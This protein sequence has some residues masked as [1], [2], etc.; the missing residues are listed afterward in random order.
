MDQKFLANFIVFDFKYLQQSFVGICAF[1]RLMRLREDELNPRNDLTEN[2]SRF[3]VY[4]KHVAEEEY[5]L[6][7]HFN[8]VYFGGLR[9]RALRFVLAYF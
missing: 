9:E 1:L 4:L 3:G 2:V 8:V 6:G 7:V 5:S